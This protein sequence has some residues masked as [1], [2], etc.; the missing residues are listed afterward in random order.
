MGLGEGE[1]YKEC[2]NASPHV[3]LQEPSSG[4]MKKKE[5]QRS[6]ST[7]QIWGA[8]ESRKGPKRGFGSTPG[9]HSEP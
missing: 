5:R 8:V 2:T 1:C 3:T 9:V 4:L 6:G 7:Q